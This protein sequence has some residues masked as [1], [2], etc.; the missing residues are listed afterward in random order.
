MIE[1]DD[2]GEVAAL[3]RVLHIPEVVSKGMSYRAQQLNAVAL[4][5]DKK[6][7]RVITSSSVKEDHSYVFA[8]Y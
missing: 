3:V 5:K 1:Y 4:M 2:H 6:P 7:T 8:L